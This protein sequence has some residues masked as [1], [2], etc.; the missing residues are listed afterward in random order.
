MIDGVGAIRSAVAALNS[1][2]IEGY[3]GRLD[4][5]C[6][7]WV[8]GLE[9]PLSV[10]DIRASVHHLHGAFASLHLHE[11]LVIGDKQFVCARWRLRGVHA[12]EYMGVA[13]KRREIDLQTCEIYEFGPQL[14]VTIWT[15]GDLGQLFRQINAES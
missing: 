11:E 3:L 1:G 14:V 5:S 13:P 12:N 4:P 6:K 8:A 15:Y 10:A 9:L 7:R 2:D